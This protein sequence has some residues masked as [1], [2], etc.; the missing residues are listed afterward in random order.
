MNKRK[1]N[2]EL[3]CGTTIKLLLRRTLVL[4]QFRRHSLFRHFGRAAGLTET[5]NEETHQ[6][7]SPAD[8]YSERTSE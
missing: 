5:I 6:M 2:Y 1:N 8:G 7:A 4:Q 3:S